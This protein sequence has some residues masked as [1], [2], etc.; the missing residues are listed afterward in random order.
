MSTARLFYDAVVIGAGIGG[1]LAAAYIGRD[2]GSVLVLERL[3][4][5]GGRFTTVNQG[6]FELTTGALHMAPHGSGGPLARAMHELGLPFDIVPRDV[7]ASF[8][9]R[10]PHV[11]WKRPWDVMRL[12]SPQGRLDMLKIT[13]R[14]SAPWASRRTE[15]QPFGEWLRAQTRDAAIHAFFESFVQFAVGV[16]ADQLGFGELRAIHQNVLRY[17]MPGTPVG[18][19]ARVVETLADFIAERG[20]D[21]RTGADVIEIQAADRVS[22]VRVRDRRTG[23]VR[24]IH[25][26]L[27]VSDVGPEATR[28]LLGHAGAALPQ[29]SQV[30]TANGL[31]LHIIS[32][33]SMIPHNGV[34]LCLSTRR[35]GA[36]SPRRLQLPP[37]LI[38]R[39]ASRLVEHVAPSAMRSLSQCDGLLAC[40]CTTGVA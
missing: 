27:V 2:G 6:S 10:G 9:F 14:M 38:W 16:T 15:A 33:K 12:F 39:E 31:K 35:Q 25:A 3:R 21:V 5:L 13:A 22:G 8:F 20:G 37:L 18:G 36:R 30:P 34:M 7:P 23:Q 4:Y 1:L 29:S 28:E 26:P 11:L 17:G 40:G 19:C 24:S 32:D